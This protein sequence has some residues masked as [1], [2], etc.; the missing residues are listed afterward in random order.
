[1]MMLKIAD[2]NDCSDM[3]AILP[4]AFLTQYQHLHLLDGLPRH[5]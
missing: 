3:R 5:S 1:M 2:A 4:L